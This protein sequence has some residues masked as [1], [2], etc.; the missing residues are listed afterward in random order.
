MKN[1]HWSSWTFQVLL[2]FIWL[3]RYPT[4]QHLAM[5]FG[6]GVSSVH[7]VLHKILP[8]LHSILV[9]RYIIWH[10]MQTWRNLAGY[11]PT[12][13]R[14]VAIL[15]CTLRINKPKGN[16]QRLFWRRDRHCFFMNWLVIIDVQGYVVYSRPGFVGHIHDSV[17]YK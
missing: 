16:L 12:W 1:F 7:W 6:L 11:F 9:R 5:H 17:C 2:T 10:D 4:L 8:F 3:R 15:D 14:V 13:P